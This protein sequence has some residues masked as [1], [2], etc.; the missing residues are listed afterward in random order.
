MDSDFLFMVATR[1]ILADTKGILCS[2]T[3]TVGGHTRTTMD[4][5]RYRGEKN[6]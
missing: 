4:V 2:S 6:V 1:H 5:M 3:I